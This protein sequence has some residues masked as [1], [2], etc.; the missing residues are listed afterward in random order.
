MDG[1]AFLK[2]MLIASVLPT[3][4]FIS[5]RIRSNIKMFASTAVPIVNTIPAI[6]AKV[7]TAPKEARHP[8]IN[9]TFTAKAIFAT[10]PPLP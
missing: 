1:N 10:I 9:T 8:K 6:P 2:P 3:P 4:A 7:K 5:S